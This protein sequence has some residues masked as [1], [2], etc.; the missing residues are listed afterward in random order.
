M[1]TPRPSRAPGLTIGV[2]AAWVA[3]ASTSAAFAQEARQRP[4]EGD[5]VVRAILDTPEEV[6]RMLEIS[7]DP[8]S[9]RVGVGSGEFRIP[10]GSRGALD[11]SGIDYEVFIPDLQAVVDAERDSIALRIG[12]FYDSFQP[13]AAISDQM[14]AVVTLRPDLATRITI[15]QSIEARNIDALRIGAAGVDKPA[16]LFF[17]T[18]HARE[19]IAP[20]TATYLAERLVTDYDT[21]PEVQ[22]LLDAV[23]FYIIPI[24]NPDGYAYSWASGSNRFWRKNRR[25]NPGSAEGV[26]LNRNWATGWGGS[27]SSGTYSSEVY[28]GTAPFSEPET[29]A[30]RDFVIGHPEI[31]AMIDMHTYGE[32]ILSPPG[33]NTSVAPHPDDK[34][35]DGLSADLQDAV[36]SVNGHEYFFGP[37]GAALYVAAG[38]APDWHYEEH[39][40][41]SWTFEMRPETSF[42][43]GFAPPADQ[44]LPNCEEFFPAALLLADMALRSAD[45]RV[46]TNLPSEV[47]ADTPTALTARIYPLVAYSS[48]DA[49]SVTLH[50]RTSPGDAFQAIP[51]SAQAGDQYTASLPGGPG[52][53]TI[54]YYIEAAA[55][56]GPATTLP[57]L[58]ADAPFTL[59]VANPY[60]LS[61]DGVVDGSDLGIL[62]GAWGTSEPLADLNGDGTVDGSDLGILLGAWTV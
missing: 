20:M 42:Q 60:D 33:Y 38:D 7:P 28:R 30:I 56:G 9:H 31:G 34:T 57:P 41:L 21:D 44:I 5:I 13:P 17:A 12:A 16:V 11:A 37:A 45:I 27:G 36:A 32:L 59:A 55:T 25:N 52:G 1:Q 18:Q 40:M 3:L 54:E 61:G 48:V 23:D 10:A 4:F 2:A 24:A 22:R 43:G 62:L 19:W 58:G 35:F 29:A 15:G 39:Q 53:S 26:D 8:W 47:E 6:A 51:M 49:G 14:D 46:L 50:A